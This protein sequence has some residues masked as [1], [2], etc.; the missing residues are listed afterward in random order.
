MVMHGSCVDK[1][2]NAVTET[3]SLCLSFEAPFR[4]HNIAS[5]IYVYCIFLFVSILSLTIYAMHF[6]EFQSLC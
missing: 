4:H 1:H 2:G 6:F 5:S 3:P